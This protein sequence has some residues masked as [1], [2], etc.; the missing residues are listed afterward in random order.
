MMHPGVQLGMGAPWIPSM[1]TSGTLDT[2]VGEIPNL[3][4]DAAGQHGVSRAFG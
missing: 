1:F 4:F 2:V 3:C